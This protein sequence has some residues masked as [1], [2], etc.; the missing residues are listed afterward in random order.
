MMKLENE[1]SLA[2]LKEITFR[3]TSQ[4]RL[5]TRLTHHIL[6][7]DLRNEALSLISDVCS[8]IATT[9]SSTITIL[10][11]NTIITSESPVII[12]T[13]VTS[14]L[15]TETTPI[16]TLTTTW[17]YTVQYG[18]L[19]TGCVP[20][21]EDSPLPPTVYLEVGQIAPL[22]EYQQYLSNCANSCSSICIQIFSSES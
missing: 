21:T 1:M 20:G 2:L 18:P 14:Y 11:T 10:A 19:P 8:C 12:P 5:V 17:S 7:L 13:T 3:A 9:P 16:T 4:H 6:L 22:S 15:T